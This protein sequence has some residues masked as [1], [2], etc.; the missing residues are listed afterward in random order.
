MLILCDQLAIRL[1]L[2]CLVALHTVH[3]ELALTSSPYLANTAHCIERLRHEITVV[4]YRNVASLCELKCAV[5][6]HLLAM[7]SSECL[8]PAKLTWITLHLEVLVTFRLA[9]SEYLRI[10]ADEGDAF[11]RVA[12]PRAEMAGLDS[13]VISDCDQSRAS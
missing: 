1:E 9:E 4:A 10:V 7:R 2:C 11:G 13:V 8:C 5:D 6:K 3:V 12:G